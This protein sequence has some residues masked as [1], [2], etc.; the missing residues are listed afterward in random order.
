MQEEKYQ[1]ILALLDERLRRFI[2]IIGD[3]PYIALPSEKPEIICFAGKIKELSGYDTNEIL[4]DREHWV[5]L[6]YPQDREQVF[7]AFNKCKNEGA[8]FEIKYRIIQRTVPCAT[9]SIRVNLFLILRV[10]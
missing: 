9:L 5:N 4:V 8:S 2:D 7:A 3:I 10:K 1:S 6:I